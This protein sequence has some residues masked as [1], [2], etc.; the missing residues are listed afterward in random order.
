MRTV[1]LWHPDHG[2]ASVLELPGHA[3][4]DQCASILARALILADARGF[5]VRVRGLAGPVILA[6]YRIAGDCIGDDHIQC[7]PDN[8]AA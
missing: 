6:A 1:T 3:T 2:I 4:P 7:G 8:A 5:S